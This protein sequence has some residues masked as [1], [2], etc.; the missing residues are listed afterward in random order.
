MHD[1]GTDGRASVAQQLTPPVP[2][3]RHDRD[4][5]PA[6]EALTALVLAPVGRDT[7]LTVDALQ[8]VG[9][10][11]RGMSGPGAL[12]A[13]VAEEVSRGGTPGLGAIV[14]TDDALG[15]DWSARLAEVLDRQPP[16]SDLPVVLLAGSAS[17]SDSRWV[18]MPY[19]SALAE[20]LMQRVSV[21]VLDR[22]V[23]MA[24]LI[25]AVRAAVRARARQTEVMQL[26]EARDRAVADAER[27]NHAKS[28]FLAFVSHE[29]RTP[30]NAVGGYVQLLLMGVHGAMTQAQREPLERVDRAQQHI[31]GIINS[32]LDYARI[33]S[34]RLEYSIETIRL[35][36]VVSDVTNMID[37][38][39]AAKQLAFET[40]A[41]AEAVLVSADREKLRQVLL[42]LM[43]NAIKFTPDRG[44]IVMECEVPDD[45]SAPVQL[46]VHD[47]GI[48]IAAE[49]LEAIFEP[50]VQVHGER[51]TEVHRGTGLGLAISRQMARGMG[52]DLQVF[53]E[54][55]NGSTFTLTLP[56]AL[57]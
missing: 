55:G 8:Q 26:I 31:L 46:H 2:D 27:A 12:L 10:P 11:A 5:G 53:S 3:G 18:R 21:T 9:I 47:S 29:L 57:P 49:N 40:R 50:F 19:A 24:A 30:L 51:W 15:I 41:P 17:L 28:H 35:T 23:R 48:G 38:Q 52:G 25:S 16:W 6:S 44:R 20:R 22:P 14:V 4:G 36:D 33:E 32:L 37:S 45:A 54:A 39:L 1:G 42:N 7:A 13:A 34:G 56:R 43:S